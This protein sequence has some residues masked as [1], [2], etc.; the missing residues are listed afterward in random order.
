MRGFEFE[1]IKSMQQEPLHGLRRVQ[2]SIQFVLDQL[3]LLAPIRR[4]MSPIRR[5]SS[6]HAIGRQ[7]ATAAR[8]TEASPSGRHER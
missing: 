7:Q 8:L 6:H 1:A 4:P 2:L 3:Q 5:C